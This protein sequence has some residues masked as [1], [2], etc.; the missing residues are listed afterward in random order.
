MDVTL[1][2]SPFFDVVLFL[3]SFQPLPP[4]L[5]HME[6][7]MDTF[8]DTETIDDVERMDKRDKQQFGSRGNKK[9]NPFKSPYPST[10][11][12]TQKPYK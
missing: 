8:N 7:K 12:T 4:L 1:L 5:D 11:T 9:Y 2:Y 6:R 10:T 3:I